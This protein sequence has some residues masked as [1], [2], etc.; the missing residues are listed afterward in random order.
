MK[1]V[2]TANGF[3]KFYSDA[4]NVYGSETEFW[5]SPKTEEG[6]ALVVGRNR[7][8]MKSR[9]PRKLLKLQIMDTV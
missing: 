9:P 7:H 3:L 8:Q 1:Q 5:S 2:A 6:R 4:F